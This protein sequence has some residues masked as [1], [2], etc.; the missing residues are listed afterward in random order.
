MNNFTGIPGQVY[1]S[2]IVHHTQTI[3]CGVVTGSI[4]LARNPTPRE[5]LPW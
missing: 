2:L 1:C 3:V 4:D 5:F